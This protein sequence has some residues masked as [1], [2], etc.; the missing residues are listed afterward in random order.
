MAAHQAPP[1]LGFSRQEH[2]SGLPFPSPMHESE[3]SKWSHSVMSDS[4][5]PHGLQPTRLLHPWDFPGESTLSLNISIFHKILCL[6]LALF[7]LFSAWNLYC[8]SSCIWLETSFKYFSQI[9]SMT[10]KY[11]EFFHALKY[12][13]VF[14]LYI[15]FF[16]CLETYDNFFLI[17]LG[18]SCIVVQLAWNSESPL[19][20]YTG[21][22]F[23]FFGWWFYFEY[24][25]NYC[26]TLISLFIFLLKFL[27]M[28][29]SVKTLSCVQL[30]VTSW[31]EAR[32]AFLF[33]NS[34]RACSK[35][36]LSSWWC[37][38]TISCSVISFYSSLQS[39]QA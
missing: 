34:P 17:L 10:E 23:F 27:Y 26:L 25:L 29:S 39:F 28:L 16:F 1:S 19:I 12:F 2:F 18:R 4:S 32:Q 14:P 24:L 9:F 31:T 30:F 6:L 8:L 22:F 36:Y 35:T 33:I 15:I 20:L 38:P 13:S 21:F 5:W 7:I 37:H 11:S 3:K